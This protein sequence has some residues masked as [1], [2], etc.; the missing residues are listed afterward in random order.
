MAAGDFEIRS[1]S[2]DQTYHFD[3]DNSSEVSG[4]FYGYTST[5]VT[6]SCQTCNQMPC[7]CSSFQPNPGQWS[8]A[9]IQQAPDP[10]ALIAE[11]LKICIVCGAEDCLV[12]CE[13]C[14]EAVKLARNRWLDDFRREIESLDSD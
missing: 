9:T 5:T 6:T 14:V 13:V 11:K 4:G 1:L 2:S 3:Y 12:L 7:I 10:L 8:T